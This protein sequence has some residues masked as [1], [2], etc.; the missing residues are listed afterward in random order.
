MSFERTFTIDFSSYR[1]NRCHRHYAIES[2]AAHQ[3]PYCAKRDLTEARNRDN[4]LIRTLIENSSE[5]TRRISAL[6]GVITRMR[7]AAR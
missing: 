5:K 4:V 1:C 2:G 7:K 6:K 3:C